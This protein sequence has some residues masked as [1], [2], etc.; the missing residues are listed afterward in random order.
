MKKQLFGA[1]AAAALVIVW[2]TA[3]QR[4]MAAPVP[5]VLPPATGL[6]WNQTA[7]QVLQTC[8]DQIA[9]TKAAIAK[10]ETLS[11]PEWSFVDSVQAVETATAVLNDGTTAQTFLASVA[12]ASDVRDA[13]N[14]CQQE[15]SDYFTT[16]SADP[17][18]Y[19]M[20]AR[21]QTI[22]DAKTDADKKL[23]ETYVL[24]GVRA[25]IA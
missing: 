18:I 24:T 1:A 21:V 8:D 15:V 7:A 12:P 17:K 13:A 5:H 23:V 9:L 25:D 11:A 6:Q 20:S 2:A 4:A 14:K 3:P 22:G 19:A 16:L 10:I